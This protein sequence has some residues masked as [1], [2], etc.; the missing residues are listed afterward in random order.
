MRP[1]SKKVDLHQRGCVTQKLSR[2]LMLI[3][4]GTSQIFVSHDCVFTAR[5]DVDDFV[6]GLCVCWNTEICLPNLQNSHDCNIIGSWRIHSLSIP[7]SLILSLSSFYLT[8]LSFILFPHSNP[9]VSF[10]QLCILPLKFTLFCLVCPSCQQQGT[11]THK[12]L[13]DF[14]IA[15]STAADC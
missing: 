11:W 10:F 4:V 13:A 14:K 9:L 1:K 2:S 8:S 7:P 3:F 12:A 6:G 5:S 15:K